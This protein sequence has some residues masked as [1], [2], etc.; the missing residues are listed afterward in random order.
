MQ[1]IPQTEESIKKLFEEQ[2]D[3]LKTSV[4]KFDEGKEHE[5]K[6]MALCIRVLMY[7]S[8]RSDG[9]LNSQS[10]FKQIGLKDKITFFST[11]NPYEGNNLFSSSTLTI[12]RVDELGAKYLP[13]L[14]NFPS[15]LNFSKI[16]FKD[17]W[18]KQYIIIDLEQNSFTRK[19]LVLKI[20]NQD[21]GAHVDPLLDK[22]YHSLTKENSMGVTFDS[23]Q[24]DSVS[25]A[26]IR[27]IA[28]EIL[29]TL[30]KLS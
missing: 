12:L 26:S 28:H 17:Y 2:I 11:P 16:S 10:L 8:Y 21:G 13:V 22:D 20:T 18:E 1:K 5:A 14:D 9:S 29:K 3:F 7:D 19:D 6:R 25:A 24:V 23:I 30:D 27:Q 15:I 4:K